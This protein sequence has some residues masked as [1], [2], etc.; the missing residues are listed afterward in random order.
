MMEY[1]KFLANKDNTYCEK[2]LT[3]LDKNKNY[4]TDHNGNVFCDEEC[5]SDFYLEIK[6]EMDSRY[7]QWSGRD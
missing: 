6:R 2:C 1:Q 5:R 7:N 4:I 3:K